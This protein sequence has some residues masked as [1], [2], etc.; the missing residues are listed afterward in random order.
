METREGTTQAG[1]SPSV[2]KDNGVSS[3][4]EIP[5]IDH[6]IHT[7]IKGLILN[8]EITSNTNNIRCSV[9]TLWMLLLYD[10]N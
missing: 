9:V 1:Y 6:K 10:L 8:S 3:L 4:Q 2:E 5:I 7:A